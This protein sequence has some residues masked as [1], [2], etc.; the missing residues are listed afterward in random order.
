M[1]KL[2]L[3]FLLFCMI[4]IISCSSSIE[5]TREEESKDEEETYVFD[6]IP[7]NEESTVDEYFLI[8]IGAFTTKQS[9]E[10]FAKESKRELGREITVSYSS[11]VNLFVVRLETKFKNK[12][13]AEKVKDE[14]RRKEEFKDAW[15]YSSLK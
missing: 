9:A 4:N 14:I 13:E 6:E 7:E 2:R 8:Q 12:N 1:L 5:E 10:D 11:E 15:V 3:I